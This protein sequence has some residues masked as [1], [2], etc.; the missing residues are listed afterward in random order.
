M[1]SI[2]EMTEEELKV[3]ASGVYPDEGISLEGI[4]NH[5]DFSKLFKHRANPQ[6][7]AKQLLKEMFVSTGSNRVNNGGSWEPEDIKRQRLELKALDIEA[8]KQR[9]ESVTHVQSLIYKRLQAIEDANSIIISS[10]ASITQRQKELVDK[11]EQL[12]TKTNVG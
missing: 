12:L 10:L 5:K 8:R 9:T 3:I 1:K 6:L 11:V 7:I 4:Q 2:F